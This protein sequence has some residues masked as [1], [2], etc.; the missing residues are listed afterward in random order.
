[1]TIA[2]EEIF[3]PVLVVIPFEDDD[4]AVRIANESDYGL[5]GAVTSASLDRALAVADRIRTGI[6]S[7]NGGM[8]YGADLPFGRLQGQRHRPA[9]R[10]RRVRPVPRDQVTG[11]A[12]RLSPACGYGLR[13]PLR[14]VRTTGPAG[15]RGT[16]RRG[17]ATARGHPEHALTH[18]V[19]GHLGGP[20][21]D[22]GH[23]PHQVVVR[24]RPAVRRR[25]SRRHR[26][27]PTTSNP[28][29]RMRVA[30]TPENSLARAADWST[31]APVAIP[32]PI[33]V[34]QLAIGDARACGPPRRGHA[35]PARH[36]RPAS[37]AP[38][39]TR[40]ETPAPPWPNPAGT[41]TNGELV[42]MRSWNIHRVPTVQPL[43]DVADPVGVGHPHVGEELLA[44][45][46]R[47]VEHLDPV[48]VDARA[49]GWGR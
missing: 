14:S 33:A 18:D 47:P 26:P 42:S 41:V 2:R 44:E 11:L 1:M 43:V 17:R 15:R 31:I 38:T 49:D 25:R 36:N 8:A 45:L 5:G 7:V 30:V 20:A 32:R 46:L 34:T 40:G 29:V 16:A 12:G 21:A 24:R 23:L 4:D 13:R 28:M 39:A 48:D 10:D 22:L 27:C 6:V 37:L 3:G 9:E 35:P 19:A